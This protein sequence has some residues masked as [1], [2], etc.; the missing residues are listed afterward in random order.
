M[1]DQCFSQF[2]VDLP[3]ADVFELAYLNHS[4]M[5]KCD[6]VS[7]VFRVILEIDAMLIRDCRLA[8]VV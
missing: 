1:M 2:N 3:T 5:V 6:S 8:C 4:L 7:L